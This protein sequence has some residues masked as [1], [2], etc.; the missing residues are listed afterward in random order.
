M[1]LNLN[2]YYYNTY[3]VLANSIVQGH[4]AEKYVPSHVR[5]IIVAERYQDWLYSTTRFTNASIV[6]RMMG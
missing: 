6:V 4:F 1:D 5:N 3:Q 2:K